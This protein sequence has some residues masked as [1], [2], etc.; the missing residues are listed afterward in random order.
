MANQVYDPRADEERAPESDDLSPEHGAAAGKPYDPR[1][2]DV[3]AGNSSDPRGDGLSDVRQAE[4]SPG[5]YNPKGDKSENPSGLKGSEESTGGGDTVGSGYNDDKEPTKRQRAKAGWAILKNRKVLV[6]GGSGIIISVIVAFLSLSSGPLE[7]IHIAQL[8]EKFHFSAQQDG[9]A[10]RLMK[11]ARFINDPSK[12]QNTRLGIIG[13]AVANNLEAKIHDAT[14]LNNKYNSQTGKFE[15]YSVDPKHENFKDKTNQQIIDELVSTYGINESQ[16]TLTPQ[17]KGAP[18]V[19]FNPDTGG[20]AL[21]PINTVKSYRNQTGFARSLLGKAGLS[22]VSAWAGT[23]VLTKRAG[24]TFHP[25]KA[26]DSAYQ[27]QLLKGGKKVFDKL[28]EQFNSQETSSIASDTTAPPSTPENS[29]EQGPN[30][31]PANDSNRTSAANAG[32]SVQADPSETNVKAKIAGGGAALVG[33]ACVMHGI[34]E[35]VPKL[36]EAKVI[37]PMMEFAGQFISLGSQAQSD[38]D[39]TTAQLGLYKPFLD[40]TNSQG[41]V[42]STW[43]Q[44]QSIQAELG[45]PQNGPDL[46]KSAQVFN[47]G[48]PFGFIDGIPGLGGICSILGSPLG[49]IAGTI[50]SPF[51]TAFQSVA[52]GPLISDFTGWLSGV[53]IDILKGAGAVDGNYINYG[54]RAAADQQY[55]SAGGTT[56]S[57]SD[58]SNLKNTTVALDNKDFQS[59][60]LAYRIFNPDD[61]QSLASNIMDNYGSSGIAQ[62]FASMF[63]SFGSI[64]TAALRVPATL[65]SGITHAASQP[66]DYH[67]LQKVGFTAADLANPLFDNSFQNGCDVTGG[68]K[69][70]DG[71]PVGPTI[72]Q[73][74]LGDPANPN[75]ANKDVI[76]KVNTCFGDTISNDGTMWNIDYGSAPLDMYSD[77]YTS[78]N[79]DSHDTSWMRVRF[80]ILDTQTLEGYDCS[81]SNSSTADQSCTDIGFNTSGSGSSSTTTAPTASS[82]APTGSAKDLAAQLLPYISQ[83]KIS[84]NNQASDCPDIQNT[85]NGVS[86]KGGQGCQVDSLQPGLLGMLLKLVQMGHTFVLSAICSDHS[87]DGLGGHAG[88]R[89]ADFNIID[90]VFMGPDDV[91]WDSTKIAAG[92]KLDQDIASFMPKSTGFGQIQCHPAFPFLSGFNT[93]ND[94][95]HHQHIQVE[96]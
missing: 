5:L 68:C 38:Q 77:A 10:S 3:A 76:T 7:F 8:L 12:P 54:A 22:K 37:F 50:L 58:E 29:N 66:Y 88:G 52:I 65:F 2:H 84:C 28:K 91:P 94:T 64:F 21:N 34:D 80:W 36:R 27:Q 19:S 47:A 56:M 55:A 57:S 48:V 40:G 1:G 23:R 41:Q 73:S 51:A 14:G 39:I 78:A 81:Q 6:G 30:G 83:K 86:I 82:P 9:E 26:L 75:Q 71:T 72:S 95:C 15:G 24:W 33:V 69:K 70:P 79:C 63:H 89:A 35:S 60:S 59:K 96:N 16:I 32:N 25:I 49:Q 17:I 20:S 93:F 92:Q 18:E 74:V 87:N 53:P 67:G 42:T 90:G 44:A 13:N 61:A 45:E 31:Q 4:N 43:N 46:P 85:A 11:I 62:G